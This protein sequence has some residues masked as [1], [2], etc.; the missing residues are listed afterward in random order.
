MSSGKL[1][2][3]S[4]HPYQVV[5]E[6]RKAGLCAGVI[7]APHY[8]ITTINCARSTQDPKVIIRSGS[9]YWG[10]GGSE[11]KIE[12]FIEHEDWDGF[13]GDNLA[14]IRVKQPFRYGTSRKPAALPDQDE[15]IQSDDFTP[16]VDVSGWG[17]VRANG[18]LHPVNQLHVLPL[19]ITHD[20]DCQNE[21]PKFNP[22]KEICA[23]NVDRRV[24]TVCLGDYGDPL[25]IDER[26][27]GILNWHHTE[28]SGERPSGYLKIAHYRDWINKH[29]EYSI[30]EL[31]DTGDDDD[32]LVFSMR[33]FT[34]YAFRRLVRW[35]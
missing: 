7:V 16:I 30:D 6:S 1:A 32:I 10:T 5:I 9:S 3:V 31:A 8:V 22:A 11:H 23:I 18:K 26:V 25:V 15:K 14:V 4:D 2:K 33:V 24:D 28:C 20:S 17:L 29:I 12:G 19:V 34:C 27:F 35:L 13:V 21:F